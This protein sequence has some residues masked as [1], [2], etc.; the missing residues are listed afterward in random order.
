MV[1][2]LTPLFTLTRVS[3]YVDSV[4]HPWV[5]GQRVDDGIALGGS[6]LVGYREPGYFVTLLA[7][8]GGMPPGT[9]HKIY[10]ILAGHVT[11]TD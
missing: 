2:P 7:V 10:P 9:G 4:A 3:Y 5:S 1:P 11:A 6:P 8:E